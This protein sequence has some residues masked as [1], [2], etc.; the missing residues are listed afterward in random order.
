[1]TDSPLDE[2]RAKIDSIDERLLELLNDRAKCAEEIARIKA[3]DTGSQQK[4]FFRPEREAQ[5]LANLRRRNAGPLSDEHV[6]KLFREVIS[7]CLSLEE[8]LTIAYLGP[9]GTYSEAAVK[10]QFGRFVRLSSLATIDDVFHEVET[11]HSNYGVV[12]VEN[13]TEGAVNRTLDCL[14]DSPLRIC[15]EVL[16][17][18]H[19]ALMA[20]RN[21]SRDQ[22][23]MIYSH[24]QS[25]AQCRKWLDA[26]LSGVKRVSVA[27][28]SEAAK[29]CSESENAAAIAG[30]LAA[31]QYHLR[32]IGTHIEDQSDNT[33]RFLIV[34][35]QDVGTSG[36]D[37][38]S[39][40]VATEN[41]PGALYEILAPFKQRG[42]SLNHIETRPARSGNWT[43]VFFIDFDGHQS[44]KNVRLVIR[45]IEKV[46]ISVKVL[47]SYPNALH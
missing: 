18:I 3:Q 6:E 1:M 23:Q 47:G 2:I 17:P 12:P 44:D 46:A 15:G 30:E 42:I 8:P 38:T 32:L 16:L 9:P 28:N 36:M 5:L 11:K 34:G 29:L 33:T 40:L 10:K 7:C 43:Y 21:V 41:K 20:P 24:E 27:S 22:I 39:L 14:V 31:E 13:S 45:K 35:D 26:N 4:H 25:F 19:H 37:K